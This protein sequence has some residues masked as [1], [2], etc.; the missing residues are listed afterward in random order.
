[1]STRAVART[2]LGANAATGNGSGRMPD[3]ILLQD[4]ETLGEQGN[5]VDVSKG[6]LRNFLIPRKL[7]QPATKGAIE[8]IRERQQAA[9]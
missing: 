9:E 6:Y 3:A 4:V 2:A 8:V 1:M 5:V 7:A